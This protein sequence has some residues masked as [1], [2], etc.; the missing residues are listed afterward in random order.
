MCL[1]PIHKSF[2]I[3]F[4]KNVSLT[5]ENPKNQSHLQDKPLC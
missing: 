1:K 2:L 5:T 3:E 4:L